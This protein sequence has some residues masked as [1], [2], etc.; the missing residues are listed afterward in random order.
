MARRGPP[1]RFA[2]PERPRAVLKIGRP[3]QIGTPERVM[4]G[5][6]TRSWRASLA[7]RRGFESNAPWNEANWKSPKF[8]QMLVAARGE[9]DDA[10]RKKIYGD[11]QVLVHETGGIGIP[12]FNSSLDAHTTKLKGLGSIPLAGLMGFTFAENVWLEG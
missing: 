5:R 4:T 12:L 2:R 3:G 8:D 6:A 11:M 9:P 7:R 10:K 1:R